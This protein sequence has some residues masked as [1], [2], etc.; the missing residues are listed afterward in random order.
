MCM[1]V[2]N[3]SRSA[4]INTT[5]NMTCVCCVMFI[6][7][8]VSFHKANI[9]TSSYQYLF[10]MPTLQK[11]LNMLWK[12]KAVHP[13]DNCSTWPLLVTSRAVY[14][15]FS[16]DAGAMAWAHIEVNPN[17]T[18]WMVCSGFCEKKTVRS[19]M[20]V[21]KN[22]G[23][24]KWMV[25]N[26]KPYF[27]MDDLGA[28]PPIFGGPPT[29]GGMKGFKSKGQVPACVLRTAPGFTDDKSWRFANSEVAKMILRFAKSYG[30]G[31]NEIPDIRS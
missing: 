30:G 6:Q 21:S 10:S 24:P 12:E 26:G 8:H 20:G 11:G 13:F 17:C 7:K 5:W 14:G 23:I 28:F 25:Y 15:I 3:T 19:D 31:Y 2:C 4:R 9:P 22:R 16:G 27:Q 1:T 29:Y 18:K